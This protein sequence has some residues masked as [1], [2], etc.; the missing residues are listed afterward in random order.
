MILSLMI[1]CCLISWL[2]RVAFALS[3]N[4]FEVM[5]ALIKKAAGRRRQTAGIFPEVSG[6]RTEACPK[7]IL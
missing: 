2:S 6:L 7:D 1:L 4:G 3:F 5:F